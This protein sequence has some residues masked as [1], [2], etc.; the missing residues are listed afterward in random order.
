MNAKIISYLVEDCNYLLKVCLFDQ[1]NGK[2]SK[3]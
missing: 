1:V 2:N 3:A